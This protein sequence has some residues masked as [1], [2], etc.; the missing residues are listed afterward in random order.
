[1]SR[2]TT[3]DVRRPRAVFA[4]ATTGLSC[5]PIAMPY[6]PQPYMVANSTTLPHWLNQRHV[7]D[8]SPKP[9][10]DLS[11]R[12]SLV[13]KDISEYCSRFRH[14]R[15][16]RAPLPPVIKPA[17]RKRDVFFGV[18]TAAA[19]ASRPY[20][21]ANVTARMQGARVHTFADFEA[22]DATPLRAS[23]RLEAQESHRR[24]VWSLG[25][26]ILE[27]AY[28]MDERTFGPARWWVIL[29]DDILCFVDRFV[30]LLARLDDTLPLI[31]GGSGGQVDMC[32]AHTFC[33]NTEFKQLHNGSRPVIQGNGGGAPLAISNAGIKAIRRA[34]DDRRCYDGFPDMAL[35]AC[36]VVSGLR[37]LTLKDHGAFIA[38]NPRGP[39]GYPVGFAGRPGSGI[40]GRIVSYHKVDTP[41]ALC[42]G[43]RIA[44]GPAEHDD[45]PE[46]GTDFVPAECDPAC[47][48]TCSPK[49]LQAWLQSKG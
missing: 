5:V 43:A 29:D 2:R 39:F 28:L 44:R 34:L 12:P 27:I 31:V 1:M 25:Q 21:I 33:N 14:T 13:S 26:H 23:L 37:Q 4:N 30:D 46:A 3:A 40:V 20:R 38:N 16:R 48:A 22:P 7:G 6:P 47:C 19:M 45:Q 41:Q 24:G 10:F 36:A 9:A 18:M 15:L 35:A 42:I 17:L 11:S 8:V 49:E 32:D